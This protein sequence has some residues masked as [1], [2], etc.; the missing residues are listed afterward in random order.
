[1]C[2]LGK[3]KP[4]WGKVRDMPEEAP[5]CRKKP[6]AASHFL[7]NHRDMEW[8]SPGHIRRYQLWFLSQPLGAVS[9]P[10]VSPRQACGHC[11]PI[12]SSSSANSLI[13][14]SFSPHFILCLHFSPRRRR[15][16]GGRGWKS[17]SRAPSKP[18]G[19]RTQCRELNVVP[20]PADHRSHYPMVICSAL[21]S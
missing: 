4:L 2:I 18:E 11:F 17:T 21:V 19:Q 1:L 7:N 3:G 6:W 13:F 16:T 20:T 14:T 15:L 9:H 8:G 10:A 5:G 12:P